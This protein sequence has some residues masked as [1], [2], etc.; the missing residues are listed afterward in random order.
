MGSVQYDVEEWLD[1]ATGLRRF[2]NNS[3]RDVAVRQGRDS[4]AIFE[5]LC[6]CGDLRCRQLVEL[7]L[8][9]YRA[10]PPGS[11]LAHATSRRAGGLRAS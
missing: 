2:A 3:I 9:D 7:T 4:T 8:S 6:E 1:S 11:V 10:T 5:F